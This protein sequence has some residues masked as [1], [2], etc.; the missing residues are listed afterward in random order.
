MMSVRLSLQTRI[1]AL[2]L[3]LMVVVQVGGFVLVNTVGTTAARKSIGTELAAGEGVFRRS[4]QQETL[5]LAQGARLLTADYA[6]K[7]AVATHD[8]NT[9]GSALGNHGKR[10]DADIAM[11]I[12]LDGTVI[13]NTL[14]TGV[15]DAFA[16]PVLLANA[17][18]DNPS[19]AMVLHGERL[20]QIAVVPVLAP[21]PIAWVA[22]GFEVNDALAR[23]LRGPMPFHVTVLSRR[24][25]EGWNLQASTLGP[26]ERADSRQN[27]EASRYATA[28]AAGNAEF[29][30][31]AVTR[32]LQLPSP[33]GDAVVALLQEP[34]ATALDPFRRLQG[35]L[36]LISLLGV[37]VS[38][39]ASI[40]IARGIVRPVRD[41]VAVA[42]RIASGD[43]STAAPLSRNDEIG[44]LATAVRKMREDIASRE[45]R[46]MDLAY[47]DTLTGLPN[48]A[49]FSERLDKVLVTVAPSGGPVAVLLLDLDHFKY[50]NDT[51]GHSIGD[52]LLREVGTRLRQAL[53]R[54][55]C[56]V[57]R[58]GGDEF[59]ILLPGEWSDGARR[60]AASLLRALE[61]PMTIDGHVVDVRA[62]VGVAACP[63]HAHDSS[64][65][66][67]Q[68]DIAMYA[69]K[70]NN[71][72]IV[73]WDERY[74]RHGHERLSLMSDLRKAVD[75]DQLSLLYQ[76]K[77]AFA[78]GHERYVEALVR[79]QH[80][81][82]GVVPPSE[83]VPFAEQTGYI[84]AIT[85]W[86]LVHAIAQCATWRAA[87]LQMNVSINLSARDV[88]DETLTE[89]FSTLLQRHGCA[90]QWISFE[91]TESA[92]LDDPGHAVE[93]LKRLSALG[94][95][96]SIDDYGT[97]YSSLAYLRR[98]PLQEL[99]IDKSFVM[100]MVRDASD[101]VIV[102]STI[103]LAH[104]MGLVV[105][106]EGVEDEATLERLR[107]LGCDIVQGFYLSRPI[108]AGE[109]AAWMH[110]SVWTRGAD[111]PGLRRVI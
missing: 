72:G 57:A 92:I 67:R 46:I 62:S 23:V 103:D 105:V 66:M 53:K 93:N 10:I 44:D 13:A 38:I 73:I 8:G 85:Q 2:F 47:R 80:P 65:L 35:Q 30:E 71:L 16:Y 75:G 86:V 107:G 79:W 27:L 98:L 29:D 101:N 108:S 109:V 40:V 91:I 24:A 96:L 87:G 110:A 50:V 3:L 77:V 61:A 18:P 20:Y 82:R 9:I 48:R 17:Q 21:V 55:N 33:S 22:I 106:A 43:Y 41:L 83:F 95:K 104:N 42:R 1:L 32:V 31:H 4:M 28:D 12:G 78:G 45:S 36:A 70:R 88:M 68:A 64:T 19:N 63:E 14:G 81:T 25:R 89:R 102:R 97:G 59:A 5:R 100:G 6:F 11:L 111:A 51:L 52:S 84:R 15:G 60:V 74:E 76:P 54:P 56:T 26:E 90:A 34:L 37:V 58:L 99:K 69:A 49:Q 94:C 7:Q 39:L